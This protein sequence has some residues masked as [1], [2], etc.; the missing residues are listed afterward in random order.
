ME[1]IIN[2]IQNVLYKTPIESGNYMIYVHYFGKSINEGSWV[3]ADEGSF[4]DRIKKMIS[5]AKVIE[6]KDEATKKPF[7][8]V[9]KR[10]VALQVDYLV[11]WSGFGWNSCSWEPYNNI[12]TI[13]IRDF[14][15]KF[16]KSIRNKTWN[17]LV[18]NLNQYSK[19]AHNYSNSEQYMIKHMFHCLMDKK[20]FICSTGD[21]SLYSLVVFL[22]ITI[23]RDE[24]KVLFVVD[25]S[26][27]TLL[28][29]YFV[30]YST[31][32]VLGMENDNDNINFLLENAFYVNN[33]R[34]TSFDVLLLSENTLDRTNNHISRMKWKHIIVSESVSEKAL[35][36]LKS[37]DS[38][39]IVLYS[40]I[41]IENVEVI[42][43]FLYPVFFE[44]YNNNPNHFPIEKGSFYISS[45]LVSRT[46]I[47]LIKDDDILEY[48][49]SIPFTSVQ[50]CVLSAFYDFSFP[51]KNRKDNLL[52]EQLFL[53]KLD[54]HPV[55][56]YPDLFSNI[57]NSSA[58]LAFFE[59]LI[60]SFPPYKQKIIVFTIYNEIS[61]LLGTILKQKNMS[62]SN[63]ENY[64]T[65]ISN[66]NT[67]IFLV[68]DY[69]VR[70]KETEFIDSVIIFDQS[71]DYNRDLSF[72]Q[73]YI[74]KKASIF[75][76]TYEN[77][78]E[79]LYGTHI[80]KD[81]QMEK[82][83]KLHFGFLCFKMNTN[84]NY[85]RFLS[86]NFESILSFSLCHSYKYGDFCCL[87]PTLD[88]KA[89][90]INLNHPINDKSL[91]L[92]R[93]R[94]DMKEISNLS[95]NEKHRP[96]IIAEPNRSIGLNKPNVSS[97]SL[98]MNN[99]AKKSTS[100]ECN[101]ES[102]QE[103][104]DALSTNEE[105]AQDSYEEESLNCFQNQNEVLS[106]QEQELHNEA[107]RLIIHMLHFGLSSFDRIKGITNPEIKSI[108]FTK[109][110]IKK[111][112]CIYPALKRAIDRYNNNIYMIDYQEQF[113][114]ILYSQV[115]EFCKYNLPR[116]DMLT[117]FFEFSRENSKLPIFRESIPL[118]WD[119]ESD[120]ELLNQL[121]AFG[122]G[123]QDLS[124]QSKSGTIFSQKQILARLIFLSR[125]LQM[126]L[127]SNSSIIPV[128]SFNLCPKEQN[129]VL[130]TLLVYGYKDPL[131]FYQNSKITTHSIEIVDYF[132]HLLIHVCQIQSD[133]S[134]GDIVLPISKKCMREVRSIVTFFDS[135]QSHLQTLKSEN[136]FLTTLFTVILTKG[137]LESLK[138]RIVLVLYPDVESKTQLVLYIEGLIRGNIMLKFKKPFKNMSP[139][140]VIQELKRTPIRK[141]GK[142][143]EQD[144][145]KIEELNQM[146]IKFPIELGTTLRV[147]SLGKV[148]FDRP[149]FHNERYLYN[150][151]YISEKVFP[152]LDDPNQK[153]WWKSSIIDQGGHG[154]IF[155]VEQK[156]S[157]KYRFESNAPSGAWI[158]AIKAVENK[159]NKMGISAN[160]A[161]TVSGPEYF[162]LSHQIIVHLM[163]KMENAD[164]CEGYRRDRVS[165]MKYIPRSRFNVQIS[166][167]DNHVSMP[168]QTQEVSESVSLRN[169]KTKTKGIQLNIV[170]KFSQFESKKEEFI[171]LEFP[172]EAFKKDPQEV[173]LSLNGNNLGTILKESKL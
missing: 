33:S 20:Y 82:M 64:E 54:S 61:T 40:G 57:P 63:F 46:C 154:P 8:L 24:E 78:L 152:S 29:Q 119:Y 131:S 145:L 123:I 6:N 10:R 137:L 164:R 110:M 15:S 49:I 141:E 121:M 68:T 148:V 138:E 168:K 66:E 105:S 147:V 72:F 106:T 142:I 81:S 161:L 104:Q 86:L 151:G 4:D 155:V 30:T 166:H 19:K 127:C 13:L 139:N 150:P 21:S 18:S 50:N 38:F 135:V 60:D 22:N 120:N 171:I 111:T 53:Q 45:I 73:L 97:P 128:I 87:H 27:I 117:T 93:N 79:E 42:S 56:L 67:H 69:K 75:R 170:K 98:P 39:Y 169:K 156:N 146:N 114:K 162:G 48:N 153:V 5:S 118:G 163:S 100:F 12:D 149:N 109:W 9:T 103:K 91:E 25:S 47:P 7:F 31:L 99:K 17:Q 71:G 129:N 112:Q 1:E 125:K 158:Q 143:M 28:T 44:Y 134:Y 14:S 85:N 173:M 102:K 76:L 77:S 101:S 52:F 51:F 140:N 43:K 55:L 96:N 41:N 108:L 159:R 26:L 80:C 62:F 65:Y 116:Y 23:L 37:M 74:K 124:I 70:A 136:Q 165:G 35:L 84:F 157:K 90:N 88:E 122:F 16:G 32:R 89:Y 133:Y 94:I 59:K 167:K 113:Q 130:N 11:Y 132:V 2:R 92:I 58:K 144:D 115:V 160:R 107:H 95:S 34:N 126:I 36:F 83:I 172:V 3:R